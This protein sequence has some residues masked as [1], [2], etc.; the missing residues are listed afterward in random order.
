MEMWSRNH[1]GQ[2]VNTHTDGHTE[3][4]YTQMER[5]DVYLR[6]N[7]VTGE[8]DKKWRE[9]NEKMCYLGAGTHDK[10]GSVYNE[11]HKIVSSIML[12]LNSQ[13]RLRQSCWKG[14]QEAICTYLPKPAIPNLFQVEKVVTAQVCGLQELDWTTWKKEGKQLWEHHTC[15]DGINPAGYKH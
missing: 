2:N 10:C 6:V 8:A 4:R 1:V 5:A 12:A 3:A 15:E 11:E 7:I 13:S 9:E 14:Q